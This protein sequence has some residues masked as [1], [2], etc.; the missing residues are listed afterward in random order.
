MKDG[1]PERKANRLATY[2]YSQSG[3]Y[4]ITI[5]SK[6]KRCTFGTIVGGGVPDAPRT[7]LSPTGKIVARQLGNMIA[8][9]P[10]VRIE[11]YVV[12]PNHIHLLIAIQQGPSGASRTPP[13]TSARASQ[14]IPMFISTLKRL[15]NKTA[16][17]ALWQRGYYDHI[18]RSPDDYNTIWHYIDTNPAKWAQDTLYV[19]D[20]PD[21]V[22][23]PGCCTNKEVTQMSRYFTKTL[24]AL[25]PYTP[26]EQ[27]KLPDLVKLN[28]NE[29]PYPP[30]PG[31]AAAVAG[32]VPGLRLYSDLTEAALCAAI[33]RHC[34]VQPENILC[35]NGSDEN[36]LL[37][38]RAFC[39]ETHPLAFA[40]I[41]YSFYPVL[42]DLLHIPQ[43]VIPVEEDFSLDLSK[44]HGLNET[45]V[46]ANPNAPTTL[47]QPVA[48]IEEVVRTNPD[49]IV[50]VD[51]AY[52]DFAGPNA[53]CVP[54][55]KKYDNVIVV[56]TFSKSRQLA[57]ARL[58][59]AMGN[60]ALIA[61]L[62]RVKFSL[63]PYNINRL[64]LKA[65]QAA[66]EDTA[67]FD[68]TRAAIMDTRAW[69]MQQLT[70]RGF[71]VLDSRANFVFA[72]TERINGGVLYKELKKSGILV[73]HFDAPRIDNWLRITIGTP[74]QMQALMD[75]VDKILEV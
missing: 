1:V 5:C 24:A 53:S 27:L 29:N 52:I 35:G 49:S 62:N 30:A 43:H 67:Y 33:A 28:A 21:P 2:N 17:H 9:Y 72:S 19:T 3:V 11:K 18:I 55:T 70:D 23:R 51:E 73:R 10:H 40:D 47:L 14:V 37:A 20:F 59:L 8:F 32:A 31:V 13:P 15:T 42:C 63:N 45:I 58:G 75:A 39:D 54:L 44:Y 68:K 50:I 61:D 65:G 57:G 38:L 64:T 36:L 26:G 41:T 56:Q 7:R 16:G 22:R 66:L 60:A 4:F 6:N 46:I 69:T 34:G 71:T 48:A 74:E 25:E 12:M